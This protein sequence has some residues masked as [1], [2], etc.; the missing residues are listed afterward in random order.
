MKRIWIG[1]AILFILNFSMFGIESYN[2]T[3]KWTQLVMELVEWLV[4]LYVVVA[5]STFLFA[6]V[7]QDQ[8]LTKVTAWINAFKGTEDFMKERNDV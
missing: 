2:T 6:V 5:I 4:Y 1:Y 3:F 7:M 8:V